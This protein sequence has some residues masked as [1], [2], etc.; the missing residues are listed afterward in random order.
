MPRWLRVI[1]GMIGTGVTVAAGIGVV[2]LSV[3]GVFGR[4][5]N[6]C[7]PVLVQ[8]SV[9]ASRD[10]HGRRPRPPTRHQ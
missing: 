1:R 7:P 5:R 9:A 6:C 3:V 10:G 8:Q 4:A 2:G